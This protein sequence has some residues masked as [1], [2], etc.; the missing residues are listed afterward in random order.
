MYHSAH[1]D[2]VET[3][4]Y[5]DELSVKECIHGRPFMWYTGS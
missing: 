4:D 1:L 3:V 5:W 2:Y